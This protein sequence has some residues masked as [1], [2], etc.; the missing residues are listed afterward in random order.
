MEKPRKIIY[1]TPS[2]QWK[3]QK[4]NFGKS[5]ARSSQSMGQSGRDT[6][7]LRTDST[8]RRP[9]Q[10]ISRPSTSFHNPL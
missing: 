9:G 5:G 2:R 7:Q 4:K 8:V 1:A 10:G 6:S 3:L